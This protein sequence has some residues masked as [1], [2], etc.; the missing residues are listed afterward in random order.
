MVLA[1]APRKI[2]QEPTIAWKS[3]K[4]VSLEGHQQSRTIVMSPICKSHLDQLSKPT[5]AARIQSRR[6]TATAAVGQHRHEGCRLE[7][8]SEHTGS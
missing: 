8:V 1:E 6:P 5:L 2:I 7:S 3:S 4:P